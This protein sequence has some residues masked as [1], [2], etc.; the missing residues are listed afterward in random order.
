ML[1][2]ANKGNDFYPKRQSSD[3]AIYSATFA[4]RLAVD[5]HA[6]NS[7]LPTAWRKTATCMAERAEAL[8][9]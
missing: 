3:R 8:R 7:V 9:E 5:C 2:F 1:G 6:G 4:S